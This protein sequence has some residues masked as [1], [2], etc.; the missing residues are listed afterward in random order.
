MRETFA[1]RMVS[2]AHTLQAR[3]IGLIDEAN[4]VR[5]IVCYSMLQHAPAKAQS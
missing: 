1:I 3:G 2:K 4:G 5:L